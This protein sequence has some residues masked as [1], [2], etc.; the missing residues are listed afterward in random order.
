MVRGKAGA[1]VTGS[2]LCPL[3]AGADAQGRIERAEADEGGEQRHGAD[4]PDPAVVDNAVG[5][6]A[7]ADEDAQGAVRSSNV[8][9]HDGVGWCE[10][11]GNS[12]KDD[13]AGKKPAHGPQLPHSIRRGLAP[14]HG[15]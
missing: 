15:S 3:A 7:K 12:L 1:P 10:G 9:F 4:G 14:V 11:S 13:D 5:D 6:E 2:R 8:R